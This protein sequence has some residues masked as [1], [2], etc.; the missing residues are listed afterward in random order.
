MKKYDFVVSGYIVA[1]QFLRVSSLPEPGIT[2]WVA[3]YDYETVYYGGPGF[4]ISYCLAKL[5]CRVLPMLSYVSADKRE[6]IDALFAAVQ[7]STKALEAP[8]P[9]AAGVAIML[10]DDEKRHMT[11]A[12]RNSQG[13]K[14]PPQREMPDQ[15]FSDSQ[16]A[17]LTISLPQNVPLFLAKVKQN[18]V[19][20]V[21]SMRADEKIFPKEILWEALE[22]ARLIFMN[23]TEEE[24]LE[25][26]FGPGFIE[27]IFALGKAEVVVTT[28]GKSGS[29]V[30]QKKEGAIQTLEVQATRPE[31]IVDTPGAGDGFVAGFMAAYLQKKP[32]TLCAQYG[33]TVS[34]FIIEQTGS[35]ENAPAFAAV[36][37]RN[38]KR[39]DA[40]KE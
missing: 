12:C 30:R 31:T 7:A 14:P 23:D 5:G 22:T 3:N 2:A 9:G 35:I 40:I 37:K 16:Y 17:I 18:N 26:M 6:E 32:L 8:L 11:L 38:A 25:E 27:K 10:Q 24:Y 13:M 29:I 21:F 1:N 36:K 15:Y 34:S 4:N 39:E 33:S 20:L 19:P 28:L